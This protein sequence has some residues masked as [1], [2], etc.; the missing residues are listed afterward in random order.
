MT[1]TKIVV[2]IM[3]T[4]ALMQFT[5]SFIQVLLQ[6]I[7]AYAILYFVLS[8]TLINAYERSKKR[9][10]QGAEEPDNSRAVG[11]RDNGKQSV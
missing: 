8:C 9:K 3:L 2:A 4:M 1:I 6:P 10:D 11:S 5:L 7:A